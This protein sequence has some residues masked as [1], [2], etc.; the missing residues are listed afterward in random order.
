MATFNGQ[1]YLAQQLRSLA[2]QSAW[3]SE[4][5]VA[6]DGSS[7]DTMTIVQDFAQTA[8]FPVRIFQNQTRLGYRANF[9][10]A[11]AACK[12]DLI[13]FCDQD[14]IWDQD[15][16]RVME[17]PFK[18]PSVLLAYHNATLI[19]EMDIASGQLFRKF[20]EPKTFATLTARP[21]VI[22]PGLAQVF[23]RTLLRFTSLHPSS[24]D[25]YCA[26]ELMPHDQWYPFWA[27]VLGDTVYISDHLTKYRL[28]SANTSGWPQASWTGFIIDHIQ[29]AKA[30]AKGNVIGARNRLELLRRCRSLLTQH[31]IPRIDAAVAYYEA[32]SI[33]CDQRL[34]VYNRR[35]L[36]GR[37]RALAS[38][39]KHGDY[40]S[41]KS[42][43]LGLDTLLLDVCIGVLFARMVRDLQLPISLQ[44]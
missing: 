40:T 8:P 19:D 5:V 11:A 33:Q 18:N 32:L 13:A 29:N 35:T 6:D 37:A 16:L 34:E 2:D 1:R 22:L 43:S 30:Y 10:K 41:R 44:L 9:M 12:S 17:A 14:D 15:K 39:L 4:L 3:P 36:I 26:G 20:D 7:D 25:P 28:H 21:W 23:R 27:S 38:L 24:I 42:S 31:E